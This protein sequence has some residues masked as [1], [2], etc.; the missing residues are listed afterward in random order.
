MKV[1]HYVLKDDDKET[2]YVSEG[3]GCYEYENAK[4]FNSL[5]E[6]FKTVLIMRDWNWDYKIY[7]VHN[8]NLPINIGNISCYDSIKLVNEKE[9][10]K[11]YNEWKTNNP[12]EYNE[13]NNKEVSILNF[14]RVIEG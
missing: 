9:W 6:I 10:V 5:E 2:Y 14:I 12:E 7:A 11:K 1:K 13:L 4:T 8:K 3:S